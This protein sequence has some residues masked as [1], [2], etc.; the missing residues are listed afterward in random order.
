MNVKRAKEIVKNMANN[1]VDSYNATW[2]EYEERF[3]KK[4]HFNFERIL[5]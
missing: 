4:K 3:Y 5:W 2:D 1:M